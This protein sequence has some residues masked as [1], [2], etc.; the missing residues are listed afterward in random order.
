MALGGSSS[1]GGGTAAC[2]VSYSKQEEWSDRFNG[3]VTVTAG[4]SAI[5]TWTTTVTVTSPQKVSA[6]WNGTPAWDSSGNTMTM[7]PNGN[8]TLAAGAST[9]FGFTVMKNGSTA[10]PALG[11]C[12]AS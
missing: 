1:G 8:G 9:S 7:K 3:K 5:S 4:G 11:A 2:T 6:T 12:S 10:T